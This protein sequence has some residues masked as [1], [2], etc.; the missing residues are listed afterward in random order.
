MYFHRTEKTPKARKVHLCSL[1]RLN[2]PKGTR[3]K[4]R[5]GVHSGDGFATVKMHSQCDLATREWSESDWERDCDPVDF[6]ERALTPEALA[7]IL[8]TP[9]TT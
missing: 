5:N 9:G 1:C 6:R 4:V 2:I 7:E 8:S 3:Y